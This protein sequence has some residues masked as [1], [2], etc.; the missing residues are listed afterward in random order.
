MAHQHDG[1]NRGQAASRLMLTLFDGQKTLL[2][3]NNAMLVLGLINL[4]INTCLCDLRL[5]FAGF[6]RHQGDFAM[7]VSMNELPQFLL[8]GGQTI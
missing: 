7:G 3:R 8:L 6:A 2:N 5:R 4:Y 1:R